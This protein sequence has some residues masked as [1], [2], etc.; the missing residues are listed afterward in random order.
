MLA[1]ATDAFNRRVVSLIDSPRW[2][3]LVRRRLTRV[4][5]VGRRSG[6]TITIP[7]AYRRRTEDTAAGTVERVLITVEMPEQKR[8]WRN[9]TGAGGPLT[10]WLPEGE[11]SGHAVARRG[12]G[13]AAYLRVELDPVVVVTQG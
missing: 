3:R 4:T 12:T 9:F 8:W 1:A 11:R 10:L 2:G 5:Y 13:R 6:R 7:I